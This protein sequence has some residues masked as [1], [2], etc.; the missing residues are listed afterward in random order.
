M[1]R[2]GLPAKGQAPVE[3]ASVVGAGR[4]HGLVELEGVEVD[5]G[6]LWTDHSGG[7][8]HNTGQ[9]G[10]QPAMETLAWEA[11]D[12]TGRGHSISW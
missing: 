1:L 7:L 8:L 11:E 2:D 3:V 9:Q 6:D 4:G 12:R 10:L 5:G